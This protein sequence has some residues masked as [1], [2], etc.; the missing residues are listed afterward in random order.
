VVNYDILGVAA[1]IYLY[2]LRCRT[3]M[4]LFM[5]IGDIFVAGG[6]WYVYTVALVTRFTTTAPTFGQ[7][8]QR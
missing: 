7:C 6:L 4:L 5:E 1:R 2:T 8:L 3:F